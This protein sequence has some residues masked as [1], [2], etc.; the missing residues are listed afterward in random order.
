M[1]QT[2]NESEDEILEKKIVVI[3]VNYNLHKINSDVKIY[4]ETIFLKQLLSC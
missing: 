2:L 1:P 3:V 4:T